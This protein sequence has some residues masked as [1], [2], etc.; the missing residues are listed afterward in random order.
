MKADYNS[1]VLD[2]FVDININEC[3]MLL[4]DLNWSNVDLSQHIQLKGAYEIRDSK[5]HDGYA[6]PCSKNRIF[7]VVFD[8][9]GVQYARIMRKVIA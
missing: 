7:L 9:D 4:Q 1:M 3:E 6:A 5:F 2:D 8:I